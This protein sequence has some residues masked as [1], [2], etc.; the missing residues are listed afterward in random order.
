MSPTGA[1]PARGLGRVDV[2]GPK[3]LACQLQHRRDLRF[4][5]DVGLLS[6]RFLAKSSDVLDHHF[7][8]QLVRHIVDE[9]IAPGTA[10]RAGH[11][12]GYEGRLRGQDRLLS[13]PMTLRL[14]IR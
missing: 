7:R 13:L 9:Y 10:K 5:T 4:V 3:R 12:S 6:Q 8:G 1:H 11:N 14:V 2:E